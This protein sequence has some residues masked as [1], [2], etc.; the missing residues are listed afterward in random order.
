MLLSVGKIF[1]AFNPILQNIKTRITA[2]VAS[3]GF[4]VDEPLA[5]P[6]IQRSGD[7]AA[8]GPGLPANSW[9]GSAAWLR[10]TADSN[11]IDDLIEKLREEERWG[12]PRGQEERET[13]S[14]E[15]SLLVLPP[16]HYPTAEGI[17]VSAEAFCFL[18]ALLFPHLS[19]SHTEH[20]PT[21]S[22]LV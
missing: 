20:K 12:L 3:E 15:K 21:F 22:P 2:N 13:R 8:E 16:P 4:G 6:G 7:V 9:G 19:P 1:N 14:N 10:L 17:D 11:I 18:R 5:L